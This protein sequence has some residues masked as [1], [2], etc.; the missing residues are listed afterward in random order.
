MGES[1]AKNMFKVFATEFDKDDAEQ[2]FV[3]LEDS[4]PDLQPYQAESLAGM[5]EENSTCGKGFPK[6]YVLES[7]SIARGEDQAPTR[8]EQHFFGSKKP[9]RPSNCRKI[10]AKFL[11]IKHQYGRLYHLRYKLDERCYKK[12]RIFTAKADGRKI[13]IFIPERMSTILLLT[14]NEYT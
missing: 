5:E 2:S 9:N 8:D 10:Q 6:D 12:Y 3:S 4:L 7:F 1:P 11:Y 13:K 14:F